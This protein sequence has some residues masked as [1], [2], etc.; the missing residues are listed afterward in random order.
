MCMLERNLM[1][2]MPTMHSFKPKVLYKVSKSK[3]IGKRL[4]VILLFL[5][6]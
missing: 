4:I 1:K 3:Y 2:N 5:F 6:L